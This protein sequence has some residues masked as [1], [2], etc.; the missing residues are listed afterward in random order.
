[1]TLVPATTP[2]EYAIEDGVNLVPIN[3]IAEIKKPWNKYVI[4]GGGKTGID[5]LL[6]LLDHNV[7]PN[8]IFW[9]VPNDSWFFNRDPFAGDKIGNFA[10]M[11][12]SIFGALMA[13]EDVND[14]YKR[15]EEVGQF[16]R[17]DKTFGLQRCVRLPS[18]PKKCDSCKLYVM[19]YV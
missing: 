11:F 8:K 6:H 19:S 10:K 9:I 17:L 4:I 15:L 3:K 13:S 18:A 12:P 7:D 2:P 16:M 14:A 1:M 5:A